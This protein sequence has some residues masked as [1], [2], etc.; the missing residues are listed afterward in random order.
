MTDSQAEELQESNDPSCK[1]DLKSESET[2]AKT[3]EVPIVV[4]A[5]F[6]KDP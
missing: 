1:F 5:P 4:L 3:E 6:K 2:E